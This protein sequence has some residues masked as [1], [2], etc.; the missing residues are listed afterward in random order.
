MTVL[1]NA[2][3]AM[4][5]FDMAKKALYDK[6][7]AIELTE[8][9]KEVFAQNEGVK[10]FLFKGS[11]PSFNDEDPCVHHGGV[12]VGSIKVEKP[13]WREGLYLR[14][15]EYSE[16]QAEF[17]EVDETADCCPETLGE[18]LGI[19]KGCKDFKKLDQMLMSVEPL[20]ENLY[21]T[22]YIIYVT[23]EDDGSVTVNQEY[24][25]CGY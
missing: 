7:K 23:L 2:L 15:D 12:G 21:H 13:H 14:V 5:E 4:I 22:N 6:F 20:I 19:N 18:H 3:S 9:F 10:K 1:E 17:F 25:D 16:G 24:Y 8:L 11:T